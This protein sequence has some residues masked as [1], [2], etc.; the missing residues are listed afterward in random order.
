MKIKGRDRVGHAPSGA[1]R[2]ANTMK[3]GTPQSIFVS[4]TM[5][6]GCGLS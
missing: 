5:M 1:A 3:N 4:Q 6:R 2:G